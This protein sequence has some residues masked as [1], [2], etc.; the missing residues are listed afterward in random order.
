MRQPSKQ[1][2]YRQT[3]QE[4][5]VKMTEDRLSRQLDFI[6][7]I[8][9]L[10]HVLR[11]TL[12]PMGRR[13]NSAEH[14]WHLAVVALL[15][16]EYANEKV[17]V[18][19]VILMVL[20]H[21]IVEV[22]AGDV[23]VYDE[24]AQ[25]RKAEREQRAAERIFNLLPPDQACWF[26]QLWDEFEQ[27]STPEARFA[28]SVDRFQPILLNHAARGEMWRQYGITASRVLARNQPMQEGSTKLWE[29]T[30]ALVKDAVAQGLLPQ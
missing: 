27:R 11:R 2:I 26:R 13:E 19:R 3:G 18:G 23:F 4:E 29:H 5:T 17:D 25:A 16:A 22:D 24:A 20:V 10:K 15:L 28:N 6:L 8:D 1:A 21:D 12:L 7:E 14:S 9:K 30:Q